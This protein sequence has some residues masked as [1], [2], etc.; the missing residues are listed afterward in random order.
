MT[1]TAV[2]PIT[3]AD[4]DGLVAFFAR[5][6][7]G[8]RTFF[9]EDVLDPGVVDRWLSDGSGERH[10]AVDG[11]DVVGYLAVIPGV[12]WSSHVAEVR[13]V[14]DPQRRRSGIGRSLARHGLLRALDL[15]LSKL[16]VEV[17]ADQTPTLAMFSALG[18][19][20]EALLKDHVRDATG[21]L[22]DL[23]TMAHF[24]DETWEAMHA[25]GIDDVVGS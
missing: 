23:I 11:D 21:T 8:D 1:A 12:G 25:T 13:V 14:V 10:V 3:A 15:G 5:I 17:V 7:E 20:A 16:V 24:V 19:E 22:R 18:F 9:R 4:R 2:R 6:P